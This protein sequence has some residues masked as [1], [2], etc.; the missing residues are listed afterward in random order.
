MRGAGRGKGQ[1]VA[2]E[3]NRPPVYPKNILK[4]EVAEGKI[5]RGR[6][7]T[8]TWRRTVEKERAEAE[9]Q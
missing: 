7:K 5:R 2:T 8:P 4:I 1:Q 9:W 3:L 6:Q